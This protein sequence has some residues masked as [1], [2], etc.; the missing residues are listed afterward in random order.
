MALIISLAFNNFNQSP[1]H[2]CQEAGKRF[3]VFFYR[4]GKKYFDLIKVTFHPSP[5]GIFFSRTGLLLQ[6]L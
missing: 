5:A 2:S 6:N 4:S 3:D 1:M